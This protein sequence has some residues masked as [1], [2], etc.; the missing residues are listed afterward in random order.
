MGLLK[1]GDNLE[2]P[3]ANSSSFIAKKQTTNF[4]CEFSLR[5][6]V[7]FSSVRARD[8]VRKLEEFVVASCFF[9]RLHFFSSTQN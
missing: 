3:W 4:D 6:P 2:I 7:N 8:K 5:F 1:S 9:F